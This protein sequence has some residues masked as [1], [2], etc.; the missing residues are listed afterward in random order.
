VTG[1]TKISTSVGILVGLLPATSGATGASSNVIGRSLP[2]SGNVIVCEAQGVKIIE[3]S[4]DNLVEG[5][6]I[7]T[8]VSG[9]HQLGTADAIWV[10]PGPERTTIRKNLIASGGA[11]GI[12]YHAGEGVISGNMIGADIKGRPGLGCA[13]YGIFAPHNENGPR[14]GHLLIKS[15]TVASTGESG[16]YIN[17]EATIAENKIFLNHFGGILLGD[18]AL[19]GN[20]HVRMTKNSIYDNDHIG[21]DI[22]PPPWG[23]LPNDPGDADDGPNNLMNY[24]V[25]ES[26]KATAG[27]LI[28]KGYL[29]TPNPK[30]VTIEF[31]ANPVPNPGGDPSGYG[32]GAKYLGSDRPNSQGKFTATL[33]G[34]KA[35]TLITATATDAD[36]NTSEFAANVEAKTH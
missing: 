1:R 15:N 6:F 16:I 7:G 13:G 30:T 28:V 18:E 36:G 2:G 5:N 31:F 35:G 21:I 25:L 19:P 22:G 26:A 17:G 12:R 10:D 20:T 4:L 14:L 33:P 8:D 27:K 23:V 11:S 24:P 29:D 34:V 3:H 32:E 9:R